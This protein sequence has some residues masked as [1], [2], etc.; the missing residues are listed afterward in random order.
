MSFSVARFMDAL[1]LSCGDPQR[2]RPRPLALWAVALV[3]FGIAFVFYTQG[4]RFPPEYHPD[5][6]SK[7]RQVVER[8]YNFRHPML[9]LQ[10]TEL[11]RRVQDAGTTGWKVAV[12]GRTAS[13]A[14]AAAAVALLVVLAGRLGGWVAAVGAGAFLVVNHQMF[15]LAHYMKEDPALTFGTA[16]AL[17]GIGWYCAAPGR[18]RA[19]LLGAGCGLAIA[20]KYPGALLLPFGVAAVLLGRRKQLGAAV[21]ELALLGAGTIAVFAAVNWPMFTD[22]DTTFAALGVETSKAVGGHKGI[23][24]SVPHGVYFAV[25]RQSINVVALILLALYGVSLLLRW[26][27]IRLGEWLIAAYP[28]ALF[29]VLTFLPKTHHRYFL[30]ITA[31]LITLAA[32]G[33]ARLPDF[34]WK[35]VA[36]PA[37]RAT[38]LVLLLLIGSVSAS[39]Y[40]VSRYVDG[41]TR[42]HR[43]RLAAFVRDA[44]PA[45]ARIVQDHR[46]ELPTLDEAAD[47]PP[48]LRTGREIIDT[49]FAPDAGSL[50]EL[51][52]RGVTHVIVAHGDYGRFFLESQRPKEGEEALFEER[53][54]FYAALFEEGEKL[55]E[56]KS[57]AAQYLQPKLEVYA[58]P[59]TAEAR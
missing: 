4:N 48:H 46:S 45:D 56:V 50:A 35:G 37:R 28:V 55:W 29:V 15:E 38:G 58:L 41:F 34:R 3:F 54:A 25:L 24:R 43:A 12:A 22:L 39:L 16:A 42:D 52:E 21:P 47:A 57:G 32:V 36:L 8:E 10:A 11:A 2:L 27:T 6:P 26:R 17:L 9:L 5:E 18:L 33:L 23:T 14:F 59:G 31:I 20:A 44:L 19:L 53:R 49:R 13:A 7:V 30:P 51:R 40:T 1:P